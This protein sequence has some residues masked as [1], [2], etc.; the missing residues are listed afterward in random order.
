[1]SSGQEC[2]FMAQSRRS[3]LCGFM[4]AFGGKADIIWGG[5]LRLLL[6]LTGLRRYCRL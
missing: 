5:A 1:M 6:T 2:P 3:S 4:S